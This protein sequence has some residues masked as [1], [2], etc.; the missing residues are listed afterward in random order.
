M[1][2]NNTE[3]SGSVEG[4]YWLP[5]YKD[6][7]HEKI[8]NVVRTIR[9]RQVHW[10]RRDLLHAWLY[11]NLPILG[12]GPGSYAR[13]DPTEDTLRLNMVKPIIDTWVSMICRSRPEPMFLPTGAD[14]S[15]AWS[16]RKRCKGL[17]RW[18]KGLLKAGK[19]HDEI[20]PR[21]RAGRRHLRLRARQGLHRGRRR[22]QERRRGLG[23]TRR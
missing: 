21:A 7:R 18:A 20:A 14:P 12:F 2:A 4:R 10:H 23:E 15:E 13:V 9:R 8:L 22:E 1:S 3:R 6:D 16:L 11:G 17:E 5:E 19:F